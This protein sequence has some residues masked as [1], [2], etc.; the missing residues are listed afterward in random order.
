MMLHLYLQ[1]NFHRFSSIFAIYSYIFIFG[2]KIIFSTTEVLL[3]F[4]KKLC[5]RELCN[6][7]SKCKTLYFC[8]S[9]SERCKVWT[10]SD[11]SSITPDMK[12]NKIAKSSISRLEQKNPYMRR[13]FSPWPPLPVYRS[14]TRDRYRSFSSSPLRFHVASSMDTIEQKTRD[15]DLSMQ[16]NVPYVF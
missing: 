14:I 3:T 2:E 4:L 12:S 6:V 8:I 11:G 13:P 7:F 1:L 15:K 10:L 9:M 5:R 16:F